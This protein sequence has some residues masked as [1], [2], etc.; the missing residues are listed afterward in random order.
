MKK[1]QSTLPNMALVLTLIAV[2]AA[3]VLAYVNQVTKGPIEANKQKTLAEGINSVLGGAQA[4]VQKTDTLKDANENDVVIY[5]TNQGVAVKA[6]DPNGF[7]GPLTVLVGF[8]EAGTIKGY[9]VLEHA[10]TPGL[11]AKASFWFQEGQKGNI[12][13][14][15]PGEKEL[16]VSKDGGQVDAITASTITSRAFLRAVNSAF[17]AYV[18]APA[19]ADAESGATAQQHAATPQTEVTDTI[20]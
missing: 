2:L 13:G 4:D 3:G 17:H 11:G 7:G 8:D 14:L 1:L 9:T 10:E 6:T 15:N 20:N 5:V 19:S 16:T 18:S 12:I